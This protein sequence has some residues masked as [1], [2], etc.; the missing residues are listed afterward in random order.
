MLNI[1]YC[2]E[3][4]DEHEILQHKNGLKASN[5]TC[6]QFPL[7]ILLETSPKNSDQGP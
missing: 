5:G 4:L 6:D 7:L 3:N 2:L 1:Q